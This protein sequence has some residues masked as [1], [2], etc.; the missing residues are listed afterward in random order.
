MKK[1]V[2]S[3]ECGF[4]ANLVLNLPVTLLGVRALEVWARPGGLASPAL[5][6]ACVNHAVDLAHTAASNPISV[7]ISA[8]MPC[9]LH[10]STTTGLYTLVAVLSNGCR[11]VNC[12]FGNMAIL[13]APLLRPST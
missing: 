1:R 7:A 4:A 3:A 11:V 9:K 12:R 2:G 10:V 8:I 6:F 13:H 5:Q